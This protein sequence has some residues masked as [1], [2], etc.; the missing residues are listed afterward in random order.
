MELLKSRFDEELKFELIIN[1]PES[2][3]K[4]F[5]IYPFR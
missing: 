3:E 1:A 2:L 5:P 4:E